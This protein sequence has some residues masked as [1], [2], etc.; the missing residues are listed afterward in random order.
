MGY[1]PLKL[2]TLNETGTYLVDPAAMF[3][4]TIKH[5]QQVV[6]GKAEPMEIVSKGWNGRPDREPV[7]DKF[8]K[9]AETFSKEDWSLATDRRGAVLDLAEAWFKRA[10]VQAT[11][12][13]VRLHISRN[14]EYRR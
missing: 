2:C 1:D 11:G 9:Q 7:A 10:L 13:S 14:E 5:I 4:A 3:P 12:K 6:V 8:M